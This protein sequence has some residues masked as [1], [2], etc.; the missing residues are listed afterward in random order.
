MNLSG[1]IN[2]HSHWNPLKTI[3]FQMILG[4][5][6]VNWFAQIRFIIKANFGNN[7]L[8]KLSPVTVAAFDL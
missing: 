5:V 2:F 8:S 4:G 3:D 6:N 7:S 1:L